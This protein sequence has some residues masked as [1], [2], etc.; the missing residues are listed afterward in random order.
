MSARVLSNCLCESS[1][2]KSRLRRLSKDEVEKKKTGYF[3]KGL[4]VVQSVRDL[5][6]F[7]P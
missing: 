7:T 5:S 2:T 4:E 3:R 6:G 1:T